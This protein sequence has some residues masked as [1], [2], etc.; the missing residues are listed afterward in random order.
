MEGLDCFDDTMR[1]G[2][3]DGKLRDAP[4]FSEP[5]ADEASKDINRCL[6]EVLSEVSRSEVGVS[7]CCYPPLTQGQKKGGL[8]M[9]SHLMGRSPERGRDRRRER[10]SFM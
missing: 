2:S 8:I 9:K 7:G 6:A 10:V 4:K 3:C 5:S 1:D